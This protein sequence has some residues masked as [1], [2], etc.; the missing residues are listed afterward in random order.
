MSVGYVS[1]S[2]LTVR[3]EVWRELRKV[4]KPDSRFHWDFSSFIPDFEGSEKCTEKLRGMKVYRK[5]KLLFITPDNCLEKL[6]EACIKDHKSYVMPTYGIVRGFVLMRPED[7]PS[8]DETFSATLDGADKFAKPV[9]MRQLRRFKGVDIMVTGCAAV[10]SKGARMGKGH[11]YFDMEWGMFRELGLVNNTTPVICVCHDCQ[12]LLDED[13]P[14]TEWDSI[15][16]WVITPTK[17]IHV[18]T[19]YRK[20]RE[21]AWHLV[22]ETTLHHI[23]SLQELK[24]MKEKGEL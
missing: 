12:V 17:T 15:A 1:D 14:V 18:K 4:A 6:R 3:K 7:V 13:V 21:L 22:D 9:S 11:G 8:G 19:S 16:D 24:E 10:D 2:K 5:A 23:P 20:P